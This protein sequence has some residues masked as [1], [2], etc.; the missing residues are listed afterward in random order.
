[1]EI[2][3]IHENE[4]NDFILHCPSCG[5]TFSTEGYSQFCKGCPECGDKL[6]ILKAPIVKNKY[7]PDNTYPPKGR[8][9]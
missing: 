8:G 6:E 2:N 9:Q 4:D 7:S 1:M 3:N 5:Y